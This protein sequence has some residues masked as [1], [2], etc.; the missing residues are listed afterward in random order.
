MGRRRSSVTRWFALFCLKFTFFN[1]SWIN[2]CIKI[3]YTL[4]IHYWKC[5]F[6]FNFIALIF[7]FF[8][9]GN[10]VFYIICKVSI[11]W[12]RNVPLKY[13]HHERYL[14]I[15]PRSLQMVVWYDH[16]CWC[17]G[18]YIYHLF[19]KWCDSWNVSFAGFFLQIF[20]GE[21]TVFWGGFK[22]TNRADTG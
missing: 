12:S 8:L 19:R 21:G 14:I 5:I 13:R 22:V 7:F 16:L 6:K 1:D 18:S 15:T 2:F 9:T 17:P 10:G 11:T 20:Q 3:W 4:D